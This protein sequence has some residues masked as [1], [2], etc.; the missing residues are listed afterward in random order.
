MHALARCST[1]CDAVSTGNVNSDVCRRWRTKAFVRLHLAS[2]R[3]QLYGGDTKNTAEALER[4]HNVC[5]TAYHISA[6]TA[7][8]DAVL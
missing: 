8:Y 6:S 1:G 4:R 3:L 2:Q 7:V 5:S